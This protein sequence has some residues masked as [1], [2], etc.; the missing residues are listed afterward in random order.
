LLVGALN[1]KTSG[2]K[3]GARFPFQPHPIG[4]TKALK[5]N[6]GHGRGRRVGP[7]YQGRNRKGNDSDSQD[8]E[9][10]DLTV[11]HNVQTNRES[12]PVA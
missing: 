6:D 9:A 7:G 3:L 10:V 11:V 8:K 2:V 12:K 1:P 4:Y 5:A